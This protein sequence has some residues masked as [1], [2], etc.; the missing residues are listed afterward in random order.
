M[1]QN[2]IKRIG[3]WS[4]GLALIGAVGVAVGAYAAGPLGHGAAIHW[5]VGEIIEDLNL[6]PSQ[7]ERLDR[8]H[9]IVQAK[10]DEVHATHE[11]EHAWLR[12]QVALGQVDQAQVRAAID[13]HVEGFR[14][15]AYQVGD[16][17]TVFLNSLD[18]SQ[19]ATLLAKLDR[20]HDSLKQAH[21]G[22]HG[23]FGSHE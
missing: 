12:E 2:R 4:A 5:V 21:D 7:Q 3:L 18:E 23:H 16:E 20:L 15:T 13:E 10:I 17:L 14:A 6:S 1:A 22:K 9:A 19:R 8:I 11:D